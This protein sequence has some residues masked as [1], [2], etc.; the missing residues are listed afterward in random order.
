M[1]KKYIALL[2]VVCLI[3]AAT[4]EAQESQTSCFHDC[5]SIDCDEHPS[6]FCKFLCGFGCSGVGLANTNLEETDG[7]M[8]EAP[9]SSWA[10]ASQFS[11]KVQA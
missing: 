9:E 7:V 2:L 3:A 1:K 6:T 5:V 4:V 10:E 11:R 8:A